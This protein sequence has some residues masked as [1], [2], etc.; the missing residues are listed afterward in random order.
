M[1]TDFL[2]PFRALFVLCVLAIPGIASAEE[3]P[4]EEEIVYF[5]G[6]ALTGSA[7][8]AP[9][10]LPGLWRQLEGEG[11]LGINAHLTRALGTR[12]PRHLDLRFSELGQLDGS[13]G[14]TA[15]AIAIDRE[16]VTTEQIGGQYKLLVEVAAQLLFFD[17]REMQ[18]RLAFPVTVQRIDVL[19]APPTDADIAASFHELLLGEGDASL[20]RAAGAAL[21]T[22]RLPSSA[23]LRLQVVS[24][25]LAAGEDWSA[26]MLE[27][28]QAGT[29]G[30]EFTKLLSSTSGIGLLPHQPGQA[31]KGTMAARFS[32]GKV[33][34]LSVP[35]PD[36]SLSL[37]I[38]PFRQKTL[39][40]TPAMRQE[41][42]GAYFHVRAEEPVS[43]TVLVDHG[44]RHGATKTIPATQA[45]VDLDAARY[46]TLVSGFALLAQAVADPR[47]DWIRQQQD[48]SAA[49]KQAEAFRNLL[50]KC[51]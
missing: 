41:L 30:H 14:S 50:E 31:V 6:I 1:R 28:H 33:Y 32:D 29:L 22:L 47:A 21:A 10:S 18:V 23:S 43:G 17:Y 2:R 7:A 27:R 46:E 13:T 16:V 48:P 51:R 45:N 38:Q 12:P 40:Q 15:L 25:S 19:D 11:A 4:G 8:D 49:R 3:S 39:A 20:A 26:Q 9:S 5:A 37:T 36:F 34:T 44:F 42:F 35:E 24:V